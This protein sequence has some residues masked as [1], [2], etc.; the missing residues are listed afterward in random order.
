MEHLS[1]E[2]DFTV[3]YRAATAILN[4]QSPYENPAYFYPPVVA[5]LMAPFAL[6]DYVTAR[7]IWFLLSH[8]FLLS[9]GWLLWRAAGRG[10]MA[11]CSIA[12]V[13]AFG[14][15]ARETLDVGQ[16]GP[17]LVL[18]IV[19]A[20]TQRAQLREIAVGI[21]FVLKYIPGVLALALILNRRRAM[22]TLAWVTLLGVVLP[23]LVLLWAFP[24]EKAPVSGHYWMGT[25]DMFSWSIPS[26]VLRILDPYTRGASL[27]HNWEFGHEAALLQLAPALRWISV[28][29]AIVTLSAGIV[30]LLLVCRGRL[31]REQMPWAMIGLVSLSLAA[32]PVCWTHYQILQYPGVALLLIHSIH[33]RAWRMTAV[34]IACFALAYQFPQAALTNYYDQHGGWTDVSPAMLYTWTSVPAFACLGLFGLA[35]WNVKIAGRQMSLEGDAAAHLPPVSVGAGQDDK[36]PVLDAVA[37]LVACPMRSSDRALR[38]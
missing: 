12:G 14:G 2:S 37:N 16:M 15:A 26:V 22:V 19:I 1:H 35:L 5:F 32:A 33:L 9:A 31:S 27:P 18:I 25:P 4:G 10:R 17:L 3:Y 34:V 36:R 28:S 38:E 30:A 21:G 7:W 13:W 6:T 29:A 11:L 24:G 23:W 20:Y 8:G